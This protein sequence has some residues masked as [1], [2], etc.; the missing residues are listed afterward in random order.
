[1]ESPNYFFGQHKNEMLIF[2][3]HRHW[4]LLLKRIFPSVMG[5]G[6]S[7]SF[8]FL[9]FHLSQPITNSL[10]NIEAVQFFANHYVVFFAFHAWF[11]FHIHAFFVHVFHYVFDIFIV[12]DSRFIEVE[13]SLFLEQNREAVDLAKVQDIQAHKNG[14]S[15]TVFGYGTISLTFA[16]ILDS[17]EVYYVANPLHFIE[18]LNKLKRRLIYKHEQLDEANVKQSNQ[19]GPIENMDGVI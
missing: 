10:F 9:W 2:Y 12:T 5:L 3:M 13:E 4:M 6:L 15:E 1:M 8:F 14:V 7:F 16:N 11:L 19:G 17:K 18:Y